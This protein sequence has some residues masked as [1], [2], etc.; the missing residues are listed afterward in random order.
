MSQDDTSSAFGELGD[1]F[2][3]LGEPVERG[4]SGARVN[5]VP[6]CV[7]GHP[8]SFHGRGIGGSPPSDDMDADG[9]RGASPGRATL[10]S[11]RTPGGTVLLAPTCPCRRYRPVAEVDRPGRT[12]RQ[13]AAAD[14]VHPFMKGLKAFRTRLER[15]KTVQD[16]AAEFDSRFRWTVERACSVCGT[17]GPTVWPT[18]AG[19]EPGGSL[20]CE[21]HWKRP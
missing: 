12:V 15:S 11:T 7:C 5:W 18:L 3:S 13:R 20:R 9:C 2:D 19:D 21:A 8:G 10:P 1:Y 6:L 17:T 14:G 4:T 16:P